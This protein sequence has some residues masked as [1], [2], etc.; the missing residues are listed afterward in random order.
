MCILTF[1][2]LGRGLNIRCVL[3][4]SKKMVEFYNM[5]I[6]VGVKLVTI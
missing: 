2:A 3:G 1:W 5:V 6:G 4:I